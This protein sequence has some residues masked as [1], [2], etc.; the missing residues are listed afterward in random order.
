MNPPRPGEPVSREDAADNLREQ[1][2]SF[3]RLAMTAR[4]D[5]GS[6][7]LK[8]IAEEFDTDARRI[9]PRSLRR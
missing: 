6:A 4:T 3:R 7:A 9:D 8:A 5:S 1:A 2:A